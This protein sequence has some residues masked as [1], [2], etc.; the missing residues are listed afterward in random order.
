[1]DALFPPGTQ[2]SQKPIDNLPAALAVRTKGAA[3]IVADAAAV[4]AT[5]RRRVILFFF[6][7]LPPR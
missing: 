4:V 6:M 5:K 2:W 3:I 1:L 7:S